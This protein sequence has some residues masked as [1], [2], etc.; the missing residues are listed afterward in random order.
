[1][2]TTLILTIT[3]DAKPKEILDAASKAL[4]DA[5]ERANNAKRRRV[6]VLNEFS[7]QLAKV[8]TA[9]IIIAP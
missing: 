7:L 9:A 2:K 1:M 6:S 3:S 8:T 5:A 4:S